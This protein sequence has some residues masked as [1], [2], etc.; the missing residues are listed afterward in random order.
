MQDD[1][2]SGGAGASCPPSPPPSLRLPTVSYGSINETAALISFD[3]LIA[4]EREKQRERENMLSIARQ[5][6]SFSYLP[7]ELVSYILSF[8]GGRDLPSASKVCRTWRYVVMERGLLNTIA[9][10]E[11]YPDRY[12]LIADVKRRVK[13]EY[14]HHQ[15]ESVME[16]RRRVLGRY[17]LVRALLQICFYSP[18]VN[19]LLILAWEVLFV[20]LALKLDDL[21]F[22]FDDAISSSSLLPL[23]NLTLPTTSSLSTSTPLMFSSSSTSSTT[24]NSLMNE[25]SN[26][27]ILYAVPSSDIDAGLGHDISWWL[28]LV[29]PSFFLFFIICGSTWFMVMARKYAK[30]IRKYNNYMADSDEDIERFNPCWHLFSAQGGGGKD[31]FS[32]WRKGWVVYLLSEI[33]TNYSWNNWLFAGLF[34]ALSLVVFPLILAFKLE[35]DFFE[36]MSW[37]LILLPFI[38]I[39]GFITSERVLRWFLPT[40]CTSCYNSSSMKGT[41]GLLTISTMLLLFFIFLFFQLGGAGGFSI[42][43]QWWQIFLP[44]WCVVFYL[45][46]TFTRCEMKKKLVLLFASAA[47]ATTLVLLPL[48]LDHILSL[49]YIYIFIPLFAFPFLFLPFDF[50]NYRQEKRISRLIFL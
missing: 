19:L 21:H 20:L 33:K 16:D 43:W 38:V 28:A 18:V 13:E 44:L 36:N 23:T 32:L 1:G 46:F 25:L 48:R 15:R 35:L 39:F 41:L 31:R 10:R 27:Q 22:H 6:A 11:G 30:K 14:H 40:S 42:H 24:T 26:H 17:F 7:V 5:H 50:I 37:Q 49:D 8:V 47:L 34:L 2:G 3:E 12:A 45:P 29:L 9:H 4:I